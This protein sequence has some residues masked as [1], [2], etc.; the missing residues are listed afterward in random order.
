MP[1]CPSCNGKK[2]AYCHLNYGGKKPN[3]WKWVDCWRC[4]GAGSVTDEHLARI[5]R[6]RLIGADRKARLKTHDDEARE[7][8]CTVVD[9]SAVEMG[10]ADEALFARVEAL[11]RGGE[12]GSMNESLKIEVLVGMI[13]SGKSTYAR[14][15]ADQGALVISHDD[16]TQMLHAQYRYEP[17]LRDCYR[18]MMVQ[19]ACN[20]L[21]AGRDVV[22]DRTHLTRESRQ[23]WI[24][25]ARG[26]QVRVIAVAF[27]IEPAGIHAQRRVYSDARGRTFDEWFKV[28]VH[29]EEQAS[30]EPL[31]ASEG[32]DAITLMDTTLSEAIEL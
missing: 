21:A 29:H 20:A 9:L 5:E 2:Q 8:G 26:A 23:L 27:P 1:V 11:C 18:A 16:L 3:E 25:T 13:A 24:D 22:V 32:F 31:M 4:D 6:G 19:L 28:A 30:A 17:A 12:A 10:R 14:K 7:L 15:R